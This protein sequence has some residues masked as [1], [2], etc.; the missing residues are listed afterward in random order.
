MKFTI[1]VKPSTLYPTAFVW[2]VEWHVG[3]ETHTAT[4]SPSTYGDAA[5]AKV[6]AE[7]Y[8]QAVAQAAKNATRYEYEV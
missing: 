5:M 3:N 1:D 7:D 6:H 8:V 4:S 2:T